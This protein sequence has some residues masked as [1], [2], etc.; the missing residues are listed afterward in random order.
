MSETKQLLKHLFGF[1]FIALLAACGGAANGDPPGGDAEP[2]AVTVDSEADAVY[3]Q[4]LTLTATVEGDGAG[5]AAV[6][7][8]AEADAGTF[9]STEGP[10]TVWTAP[11]SAGPVAITASLVGQDAS[12]TVTVTVALCSSGAFSEASDP[13]VITNVHQLQAVA[14]HQ[15]GHFALGDDIDAAGTA[16][17]NGGAGF[18]PIGDFTGTFDGS[19]FSIRDLNVNRPDAEDE[20]GL[21]GRIG[22][23]GTVSNLHL[24]D[25]V[26][27]GANYVGGLAGRNQGTIEG[28]S[29]S[30]TVSGADYV[31]G[32]AGMNS[33]T[34]EAS[35]STAVVT[36]TIRIGGLA[37]G[38]SGSGTIHASYSDSRPAGEPGVVAADGTAGG[39][40]GGNWGTI[41]DSYSGST[42]QATGSNA[43]GLV[44]N[45]LANAGAGYIDRSYV[46]AGASVEG[47]W[48][49]GGLVGN[50]F[51][52]ITRSYSL[53]AS[54][55]GTNQVG[56][57]VGHNSTAPLDG[58][59]TPGTIRE[60]YSMSW[61]VDANNVG[62][63][64]GSSVDEPAVV[65]TNS[66]WDLQRARQLDSAGGTG[67][68]TSQMVEESTFAGWDFD[69]VWS[70]DEGQDTP[71][72]ISN[73]R[74]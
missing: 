3:G 41:T 31:G 73:P 40:V 44:G 22:I 66:Y 1:G 47:T 50:N 60:S 23:G 45:N 52:F 56:G 21:F 25:V 48:N 10:T 6:R 36:G 34:V 38:N 65:V 16:T 51:G 24:S 29:T 7:W 26:I 14:E 61:V 27:S 68:G 9:S 4:S 49:V 62:G 69:D 11:S 17:W 15:A 39:L 57:L 55:E 42:V 33:G 63:L 74:R 19:G 2:L 35:A 71:D 67:V 70:I 59:A 43:G 46:S 72:L 32:L 5:E 20:V 8:S 64:V 37:G 53:A 12:D 13:C 54:V 18:E 58:V 28:S 30:G